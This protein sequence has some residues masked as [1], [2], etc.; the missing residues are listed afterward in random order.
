MQIQFL[1][2]AG[3]VTGSSFL[4]T[5]NNQK[6]LIDMG[7]FQGSREL[8][9]LNQ[10]PLTFAA[11]EINTVFLTHAHLDHV[12][13]MPIL[14]KHGFAGSVYMTAATR[15][16]AEVALLDAAKIMQT[17]H[18]KPILYTE[19]DVF[20]LLAHTKIV[21]YGEEINL[22]GFTALFRDA[23]HML[24]SAS[25]E[26]HLG[27]HTLAYSGDLGNSPEELV[28]PTE[29]I[30]LADTVIMES[31]YGDRNHPD[32]DPNE[33][34]IGEIK[35]IEGT[36]GALLIPSF[37][38]ERTQ[39]LLHKIA[40]FKADGKISHE[41]PVYL[42]SPM[43]EA[44]TEIYKKFPSLYNA[45]L[46]SDSKSHDP[47]SFPDLRIVANYKESQKIHTEAGAKVIIAGSGMMTG[48]RIL[49]H[50]I[51]YL[52]LSTTSLLIVG[53]QAENTIGRQIEEGAKSVA[54]YG[55]EVAVNSQVIMIHSMSAH[56]DKKLLLR[57]LKEIE[58][59]NKIFL[60][61]GEN[62][63][64][65]ALRREIKKFSRGEVFLPHLEETVEI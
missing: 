28:K 48:G 31:T 37:S 30:K 23:G 19:E 13:R 44:V 40:H 45:E 54:I 17:E 51:H 52:P 12:G 18:E 5:N 58:G 10:K 55:Q 64:R 22:G 42:D 7:M 14:M 59:V 57:W 56:A 65:E 36:G 39:A 33:V 4:L 26:I 63:S 2:A 47:F 46:F 50:A 32:E 41:I 53:F 1:G 29:Y 60:V 16:I 38:V 21:S 62:T 11:N 8:E 15:E 34:I 61:H 3:T 35:K 43:G 25:I 49:E 27:E 20:S 9:E 6:I 24:G